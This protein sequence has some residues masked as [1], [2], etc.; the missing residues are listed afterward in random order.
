MIDLE[1]CQINSA[2]RMIYFNMFKMREAMR[3][4]QKQKERESIT[5]SNKS[6]EILFQM[7]KCETQKDLRLQSTIKVL[8]RG[9]LKK[10]TKRYHSQQKP[11]T[12][13]Q[14]KIHNLLQSLERS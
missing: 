7:R 5:L 13:F 12:S 1:M 3:S 14:G 11:P 6:K 9:E 2:K 10:S 4:M 8:S